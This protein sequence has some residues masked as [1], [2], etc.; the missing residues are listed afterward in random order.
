MPISLFYVSGIEVIVYLKIYIYI[1]VYSQIELYKYLICSKHGTTYLMQKKS[2]TSQESNMYITKKI[3]TYSNI[4]FII[5][6]TGFCFYI[7]KC[8][9]VCM[10]MYVLI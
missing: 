3:E 2:W 1:Y 4:V 6:F 9:C 8:M 5:V 7:Y 10:C